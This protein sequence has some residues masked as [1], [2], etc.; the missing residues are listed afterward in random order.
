MTSFFGHRLKS[1]WVCVE[2]ITAMEHP[3]QTIQIA[4]LGEVGSKQDIAGYIVFFYF[5]SYFLLFK[6][7]T[8]FASRCAIRARNIKMES[9]KFRV[10]LTTSS[11]IKSS[12]TCAYRVHFFSLPRIQLFLP[13][14]SSQ[15][16]EREIQQQIDDL[17]KEH[18]AE[19]LKEHI[20]IEL[21]LEVAERKRELEQLNLA[22]HNS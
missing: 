5:F 13:D 11:R 6:P 21:Q 20:P 19:C 12:K 10:F 8:A 7:T 3:A 9:A 4:L 1:R 22:L 16:V 2:C 14:L 18:V 15:S 17:V